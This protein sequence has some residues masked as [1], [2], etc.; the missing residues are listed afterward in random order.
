MPVAFNGKITIKS[1]EMTVGILLVVLGIIMPSFLHIGNF[2]IYPTLHLALATGEKLYVVLAAFKLVV[3]NG[4]RSFPHY[5]GAFLIGESV[6]IWYMEKEIKFMKTLVICGVIPLVY[7][8]IECFYHIRYDFGIPAVLVIAM[9]VILGKIDFNLVNISKKSLMVAMMIMAFQWL[10]IIPALSGYAFG[11]GE[12]SNDIKM[13]ALLLESDDF[14]QF[15]ALLFFCLLLLNAVL[16][17]KLILDENNLKAMEEEKHHNQQVLMETQMRVLESRTYMELQH[18][19]HDL[20]SP[21]TTVQALVGVVK[22]G[23]REE[24]TNSYL[25]KIE[26]SVE[27]MSSMISEILYEESRSLISTEGVISA[28]LSQI[29]G[30]EY[31]PIVRV[32]N[33]APELFIMV[34]KIRFFRA[35]INLLEN[36]F[37]AVKPNTGRIT[38]AVG[39]RCWANERYACL[40]V[41]D[42]GKGISQ[43]QL[44]AVW[45]RGFSSRNSLGL[46]LSFV[47]KVIDDNDGF[48]KME[49]VVGV[50]TKVTILIPEQPQENK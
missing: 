26:A 5:L 17:C 35:V 23:C 3:L 36:A 45:Q 48:V 6:H 31:V 25:S 43:E 1:R 7:L 28:I 34:N 38:L 40:T 22:L 4:I 47:Q 20:K 13:A 29:S 41:Q 37:Y 15:T 44:K 42:N 30:T 19:V 46:G 14:L 12:T 33:E 49:S 16:L 18:L 10:D 8:I 32:E 11:R 50:G 9:L 39:E 21:L 24:K 2:G 27:R